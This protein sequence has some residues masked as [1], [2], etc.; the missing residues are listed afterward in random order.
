MQRRFE[1]DPLFQATDLLLQERVPKAVA[2]LSAHRRVPTVARA[3]SGRRSTPVRVFTD[4]DTPAPEVHLLSNGR[5]HVMVTQRRRRLQPL[6]RPGRHALARRR[7][8]RLLGHVLLPARCRQRRFW[9]TAY[10]PTLKPAD[11][12]EA[13]FSRGPRR[14]PPPRRRDRHPHRD[15]VSPEDDIELRR[16]THHQ[17]RPHA[18]APSS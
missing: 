1:A 6:A 15:R 2:R 17:P 13:I 7:H 18:S 16:I 10:Q 4:P 8:A 11:S 9:S 12:Y 5:Y 14:V 3:A